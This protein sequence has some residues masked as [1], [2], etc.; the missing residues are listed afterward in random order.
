VKQNGKEGEQHESKRRCAAGDRERLKS[1]RTLAAKHRFIR[2]HRTARRLPSDPNRSLLPL[3][4]SL[5]SRFLIRCPSTIPRPGMGVPGAVPRPTRTISSSSSSPSL[6]LSS[7]PELAPCLYRELPT[8]EGGRGVC[9]GWATCCA[10]W[11][12]WRAVW[13]REV[14]VVIL[15]RRLLL[16]RG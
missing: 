3:T 15:R 14:V 4:G 7:P 6:L 1:R 13:R 16:E 5:E 8:D 10:T 9:D 2:Q 11:R 12:F